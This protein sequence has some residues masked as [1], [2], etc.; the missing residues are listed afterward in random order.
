MSGEKISA[1]TFDTKQDGWEA[2]RGFI[3][4]EIP[5]PVL[6]EKVNPSD[7]GTVILKIQ[8]AGVCGSDRG[9]FYRTAFKDL[10]HSSLE[11]QNTSLR[12]LGHEFFGE[13]IQAGSGVG[14][15]KMGDRVSGDSHITCGACYQC[16]IGEN[17][18][19]TNEKILGIS[20]DGIFAEY[21]K[22]PARN[23][24]KVDVAKI[25]PEI[26]AIFDPFGN[27]VHTI[28]KTP[29]QGKTVA[30]FGA[31]PIGMFAILLLKASGARKVIVVDLNQ[32]NL[33]MAKKLGA[34][35]VLQITEGADVIK[36]IMEFTENVGVDVALEMAGPNSSVINAME[37]VRRGGHVMLFGLKDGDFIIPKFSKYIVK[38]ITMHGVIGRR[39][40]ETWELSQKF[41]AD[42]NNGIQEKIWNVM[43]NEGRDTILD[44]KAYDMEKVKQAMDENPKIIFKF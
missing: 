19:C 10:I 16:N 5:M 18:V 34:D 21:V 38:G 41:L 31:G 22:I 6:D 26:A 42:T 27:A 36:N 39:I 4:R 14:N 12:I 29:V 33:E 43:L 8:Y 44:F 17:N 24:W 15:V 9:I 35:E 32:K 1:L 37:S 2:S 28:S 7:A 30:V 23:L 40:F 11:K 20:T 25:R 3:K 13:I